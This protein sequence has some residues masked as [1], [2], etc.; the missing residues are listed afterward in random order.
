MPTIRTL[1]LI[2][3]AAWLAGCATT[4]G[5][6]P[7]SD[8]AR[9]AAYQ[10]AKTCCD[11]P[12]AFTFE[13]LPAEGTL[14]RVID[15]QSP[16][17][18]FQSGR[19]HFAAFR[20]PPGEEPYRVK[21]KGLFAG[22]DRPDGYVFYPV[23]A[24]LDESMFVSRV[25]GIDNLRLDQSLTVPGG[26]SGLSVTV[27]FDPRQASERYLVVFTPAVLFGAAP[28]E[29]REGDLLTAA[30]QAW[31]ERNGTALVEPSPY[32]RIEITVIPG[33]TLI[34]AGARDD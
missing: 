2:A 15:T 21:V 12:A 26:E 29:H 4:G 30:T 17:F 18:E 22:P 5:G 1:A 3:T 10:R 20:L 23:V 27:P 19:S 25:T 31:L 6:L 24:L 32:G 34:D 33:T 28:E 7:S 14:A 8:T 13:A 11:D 16:M 9:L